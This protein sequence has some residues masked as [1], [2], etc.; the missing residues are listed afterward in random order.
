[1]VHGTLLEQLILQQE[2][3]ACTYHH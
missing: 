2:A 3:A 1:M